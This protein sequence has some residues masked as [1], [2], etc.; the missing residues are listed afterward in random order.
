MYRSQ[1]TVAYDITD[2]I[3]L[4]YRSGGYAICK[5]RA[6]IDHIGCEK[7]DDGSLLVFG[8]YTLFLLLKNMAKKQDYGIKVI[9]CPFIKTVSMDEKLAVFS[10]SSMLM[11]SLCQ[12]PVSRLEEMGTQPDSRNPPYR[13]MLSYQIEF[14]EPGGDGNASPSGALM[15]RE[16]PGPASSGSGSVKVW[17]VGSSQNHTVEQLL[18]MDRDALVQ[19]SRDQSGSRT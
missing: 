10:G 5:V 7:A 6:D 15:A 17:Q 16:S 2:I 14:R 8:E 13:I 18:G 1:S 19:L 3:N 9:R 4:Q 12:P 11:V